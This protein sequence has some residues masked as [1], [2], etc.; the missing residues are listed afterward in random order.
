MLP[1]VTFK[2]VDGTLCAGFVVGAHHTIRTVC[3][4]LTVSPVGTISFGFSIGLYSPGVYSVPDLKENWWY[5]TSLTN[6]LNCVQLGPVPKN[7]P[8][9]CAFR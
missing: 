2:V 6:M 8:C 3:L 4:Y 9:H 7:G 1:P 5:Q